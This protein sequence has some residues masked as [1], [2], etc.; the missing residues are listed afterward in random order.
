MTKK[1]LRDIIGAILEICIIGFIQFTI[2][3]IIWKYGSIYV[4]ITIIVSILIIGL[5]IFAIIK[6]IKRN[7]LKDWQIGEMKVSYILGKNILDTQY[8][9]NNLIINAE[10]TS[11]QIDHIFI[12]KYGIWCIETKTWKGLIYGNE[13]S[14][15][16]TQ[17]GIGRQNPI[18]QNEYHIK[19]LKNIIQDDAPIHNI[20]VII[21]NNEPNNTLENINSTKVCTLE[22][23]RLKLW[24][25]Q[26]HEISCEKMIEYY[27]TLLNIKKHQIS[28][29][30]HIKNLQANK[31]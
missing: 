10:N 6:R 20:V 16:W 1:L 29:K 31:K 27:D 2:C 12:N 17:N 15:E 4:T 19:H 23:L 21:N 24:E 22:T 11:T 9:I 8:K 26:K 30:Q 18:K 13:T 7:N 14:E 3:A 28:D 5:T 25:E